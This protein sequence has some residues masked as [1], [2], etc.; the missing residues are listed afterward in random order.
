VVGAAVGLL[1]VFEAQAV[2][3]TPTA[4]QLVTRLAVLIWNI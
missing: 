4:T 2:S 1:A 3:K